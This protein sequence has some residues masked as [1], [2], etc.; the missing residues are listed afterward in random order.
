MTIHLAPLVPSSSSIAF[1]KQLKDPSMKALG[2]DRLSN[3]FR[4]A[5]ESLCHR[6]KRNISVTNTFVLF[7]KTP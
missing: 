5:I 7:C 4:K 1:G 2:M 3:A 6:C